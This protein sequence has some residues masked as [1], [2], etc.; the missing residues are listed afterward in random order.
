VSQV[1]L[2]GADPRS[3]IAWQTLTLLSILFHH[4]NF[5]LPKAVE[6]RQVRFVVTPRMHG[7]HHSK[8][9]QDQN[10]NWSGGLTI[11]DALHG[12]LNLGGRHHEI[13]IGVPG[14]ERPDQVTLPKLLMQPFRDEPA[15]R[16]FLETRQSKSE[17][18]A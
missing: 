16:A 9:P 10:S 6:D 5:R 7:I 11:W 17:I 12:T 1:L 18:V 4:S 13:D 15:I 2:I 8:E 3:L 14:F